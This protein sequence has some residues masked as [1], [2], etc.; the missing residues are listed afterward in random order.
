M[1]NMNNYNQEYNL[2][3]VDNNKIILHV[4][5]KWPIIVRK[6][7]KIL[8]LPRKLKKSLYGRRETKAKAK[9]LG[10]CPDCRTSKQEFFQENIYPEQYLGIVCCKCSKIISSSDNGEH[11]NAWDDI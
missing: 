7:W 11:F 6:M 5:E 3:W 10:L 2:K 4:Y 9:K 1:V 8:K